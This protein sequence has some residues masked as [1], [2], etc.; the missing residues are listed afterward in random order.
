MPKKKC[1]HYYVTGRCLFCG[2]DLYCFYCHK[3]Y[4]T[5]RGFKKHVTTHHLGV[6]R[7]L[8]PEDY[9]AKEG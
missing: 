3:S 7:N 8:W 2:E 1:Q 5:F 4:K 9:E 6:A